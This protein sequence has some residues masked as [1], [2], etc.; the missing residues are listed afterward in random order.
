MPN[1][2]PPRVTN[3]WE[4]TQTYK[5]PDAEKKR[6]RTVAQLREEA[7]AKSKASREAAINRR[8]GSIGGPLA[9]TASVSPRPATARATRRGSTG[10]LHSP[11]PVP[12]GTAPSPPCA[13]RAEDEPTSPKMPNSNKKSRN[14]SGTDEAANEPGEGVDP[15]LIRFL[16]SMKQD[17]VQSTREAVGAIEARLDRTEKGLEALEKKVDE[18]DKRISEQIVAEVRRSCPKAPT[19]LPTRPGTETIAAGQRREE[20]YHLCRRSLKI[21]PVEGE[22]LPDAVRGFLSTKL[23]IGGERIVRMGKI[24]VSRLPNKAARE[25]KEVIATFECADDRDFV[26]SNGPCLAGQKEAGM[27]LHVPGHLMDNLSAL[28][29]LAYSIKQ[30]NGNIKRAVKFDDTAQ[31]VYLDI[32]IAGNWRKVTPKEA[33]EALKEVPSSTSAGSLSVG[34]LTNLI[35]GREVP[36]LTVAIVPE[37]GMEE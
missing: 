17:I 2:A 9:A 28:N 6:A 33:K 35:Q 4:G 22:D 20:A 5:K 32:C 26:K 29:G 24:E 37:D 23:K 13:A 10:G 7:A 36:G 25:R 31:D 27:S 21:W 34:D 12:A 3:R 11:E 14:K 18:T 19:V 16:N 1:E 15:A 8:R 30:K